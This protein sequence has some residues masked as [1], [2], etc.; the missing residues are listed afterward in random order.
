[1]FGR[2]KEFHGSAQAHGQ[3]PSNYSI[4]YTHSGREH[5]QFAHSEKDRDAAL[6]EISN[7]G[8]KMHSVEKED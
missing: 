4:H 3:H 5:T 6:N 2:A 1:M 7:A 8:G